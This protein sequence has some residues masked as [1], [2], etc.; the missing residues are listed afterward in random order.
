MT[1]TSTND[2]QAYADLRTLTDQ[3]M[4]AVRARLAE[5][6]SPLTRERGAR[7]VTDDMLTGAKEAKLIRSAAMG[8][9]RQGRTLKEV[10][11]LTGLSVPRVDQLLRAK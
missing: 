11:E 9:L 6:D 10:A 8:E 7:L 1:D 5:I 2:E 4:Q 3:Y